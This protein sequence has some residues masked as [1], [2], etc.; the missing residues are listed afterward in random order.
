MD[1]NTAMQFA[2]ADA[3]RWLSIICALDAAAAAATA[4]AALFNDSSLR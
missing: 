1:N 4:A 3:R 2:L